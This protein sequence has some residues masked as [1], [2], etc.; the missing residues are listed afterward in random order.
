MGSMAK[1]DALVAQAGAGEAIFV[2]PAFPDRPLTLFAARPHVFSPS[3]PV[4]FSHHGRGRNGR[5]YR[6]YFL[7]LVDEFNLLVIAPQFSNEAFP[8]QPWYN[9]GNLRDAA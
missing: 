4:L 9:S 6:D 1:L 7:K 8:G 2:D 5:D 3:T